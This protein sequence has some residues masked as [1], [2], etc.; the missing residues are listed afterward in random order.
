MFVNDELAVSLSENELLSGQVSI[1]DSLG[2]GNVKTG[3]FGERRIT[4]TGWNYS[5]DP[6]GYLK[7]MPRM[8]WIH[9]PM[10]YDF[11]SGQYRVIDHNSV[12]NGGY[13]T[14]FAGKKG[15]SFL[16]EATV[17]DMDTQLWPSVGLL[18][19]TDAEHYEIGRASCRE[20]V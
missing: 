18:A 19:G 13:F 10:V 3:L 1:R 15:E 9:S 5:A 7:D 4:F 8:E 16:V 14:D 17:R 2:S 11:A 6:S 12:A 20:R